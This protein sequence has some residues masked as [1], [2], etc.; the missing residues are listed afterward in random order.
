MSTRLLSST[1]QDAADRLLDIDASTVPLGLDEL[2]AALEHAAVLAA[3]HE[4]A[5]AH[6]VVRSDFGHHGE[7]A[8]PPL[9]DLLGKAAAAYEPPVVI[10][11]LAPDE[12]PGGAR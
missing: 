3:E 11:A 1:L 7:P 2:V 9:V 12:T 5:A 6:G 4:H 8:Y 10:P